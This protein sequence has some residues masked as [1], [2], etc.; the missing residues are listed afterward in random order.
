MPDFS[1]IKNKT[2][3]KWLIF[4]PK[5][6][7]RPNT[8]ENDT[9]CP[10]CPVENE[11]NWKIR[12]VKNKY[13][14][15]EIH[16]VI[17]HSPD[18][19]KNF[20][21]FPLSQNILIF[22]TFRDRFAQLESTGKVFIF[23]NTGEE[24]AESMIHPHTQLAVIP[25][26]VQDEIEPLPEINDRGEVKETEHF[27]IFCPKTTEWPDEV[28]IKAK[29]ENT[30]FAGVTDEEI[31]D[32]TKTFFKLLRI[33]SLRYHED[34]FPFN[35][36]INSGKNWYLRLIPRMKILG[37]FEIGTGISINTQDPKETLSF[38][39]KYLDAMDFEEVKREVWDYKTKI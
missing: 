6:E 20:T 38:I 23:N 33:F 36:Y 1:F 39:K 30:T 12:I 5:R 21:D 11:K 16:E 18:H 37:G 3:G 2:S 10:F 4:A 25:P 15:A 32:L 19:E 8:E 9:F 22:K 28:W 34:H 29:R 27:E 17:I 7:L 31:S 26:E 35:F 14:F 13:P 24:A